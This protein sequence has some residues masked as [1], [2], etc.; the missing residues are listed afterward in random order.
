MAKL[1][2]RVL[3]AVSPLDLQR[4]V[5]GVHALALR[6]RR[7]KRPGVKSRSGA[8]LTGPDAVDRLDSNGVGGVRSQALQGVPGFR[9]GSRYDGVAGVDVV[10]GDVFAVGYRTLPDKRESVGRGQPQ[11]KLGDC[12]RRCCHGRDLLGRRP[13]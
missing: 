12:C 8:E 3:E 6:R 1:S 4:V 5:V 10:V 13:F 9:S 2:A 11:L 7:R